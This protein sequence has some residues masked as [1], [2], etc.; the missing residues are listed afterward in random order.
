MQ[1]REAEESKRLYIF[2]TLPFHADTVFYDDVVPPTEGPKVTWVE[3]LDKFW[4]K[5]A[6]AYGQDPETITPDEAAHDFLEVLHHTDPL[7]IILSR[8]S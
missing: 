4:K 8:I 7:S 3:V 2:V 1:K 5:Y 6:K